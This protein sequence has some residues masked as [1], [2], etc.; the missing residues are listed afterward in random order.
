VGGHY[1][2][3]ESS[4]SLCSPSEQVGGNCALLEYV[5]ALLSESKW[6]TFMFFLQQEET[7]VLFKRKW[8]PLSSVSESGRT[9]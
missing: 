3:S 1:V 4:E 6:E 2:L 9:L 8:R 7:S 5:E